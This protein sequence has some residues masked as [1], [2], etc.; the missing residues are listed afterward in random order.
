MGD[1]NVVAP[2]ATGGVG[3]GIALGLVVWGDGCLVPFILVVVEEGYYGVGFDSEGV[4]DGNLKV[5]AAAWAVAW[6][7]GWSYGLGG[8]LLRTR[9]ADEVGGRCRRR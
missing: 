8:A 5:G 1:D 9:R 7:R 3:I 2:D 6:A 4:H